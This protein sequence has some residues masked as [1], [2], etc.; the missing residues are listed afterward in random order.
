MLTVQPVQIAVSGLEPVRAPKTAETPTAIRGAEAGDRA[1]NDMMRDRGQEAERIARDVKARRYD[2]A[3]PVGPPP[4]FAANVLEAERARA[5]DRTVETAPDE[6]DDKD[7]TDK[8][9]QPVLLAGQT[10]SSVEALRQ[11][12]TGG[13]PELDKLS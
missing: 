2:P 4:T 5:L 7:Q 8:D 12:E 11:L 1:R 3:E 13:K 6:G 9:P 10:R